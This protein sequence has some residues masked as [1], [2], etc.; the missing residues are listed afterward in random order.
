[1]P[2]ALPQVQLTTLLRQALIDEGFDPD[3]FAQ[4]FAEWKVLGPA[5][6][7]TDY[8]FG[9]D[10]FYER[11]KRC[12]RR[13]L[14]H[15]HLPPDPPV[16]GQRPSPAFADWELDSQRC[17]RKTSDTSLIYAE[18]PGHGFLLIYLAREPQGHK[19]ARMDTPEAQQLMNQLADVAEQFI[20]SGT[21]IL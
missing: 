21:I 19:L 7:Y 5:G 18:D 15:V 4:Y 13:V 1:M 3:E 17:R 11:P 20:F 9:K 8:Y 14:R 10:G 6:E 2:P 12:G 16:D